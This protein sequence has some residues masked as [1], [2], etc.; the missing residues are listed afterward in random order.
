MIFKDCWSFFNERIWIDGGPADLANANNGR[1]DRYGSSWDEFVINKHTELKL[2]SRIENNSFAI[3]FVSIVH[4][5]KPLL[6]A[7]NKTSVS[8]RIDECH[9][10][11]LDRKRTHSIGS[12]W[13]VFVG[14]DDIA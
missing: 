6:Y 5:V 13:S 4:N 11:A 8:T 14:R 12:N 9:S 1:C 10:C 3:P 2:C 7:I